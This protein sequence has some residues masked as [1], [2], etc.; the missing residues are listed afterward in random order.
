MKKV[1]L[2]FGLI[3]LAVMLFSQEEL[4]LEI[5]ISGNQN[6]DK[7]LILSLLPFEVGDELN[8][9][10]ISKT[11]KNL[12]QLGVFDDVKFFAEPLPQGI[13]INIEVLEYPIINSIEFSGNKKIKDHTFEDDL[14]M[15]EGNYWSPFLKAETTRAISEKYKE[16]GYHM[17]E[18]EFI[19]NSISGNKIDLTV[20]ITENS[21][22]VIKKINIHGNKKVP[23]KDIL[24][25]IKT[26]KKSLFRS[27]KFEQEKFIED[28]DRI[29]TYYNKNGFIDANII[30]WG[31]KVVDGNFIIDIYVFEGNVYHF[32]K[33]FV[34]GNKRFTEDI[35]KSQFKFNKNEI[36]D[37]EK[38]NEQLGKVSSMY[39]EEG[40]IYANFEHELLKT[41]D[42]IDIELNISENNRAQVRKIHIAGNR[43]T[44]EKIIRRQLVISPG[45]YFQQSKLMKSQQNI[46]NLGF[47]E[48]DIY[49]DNPKIINDDGDI[50]LTINV[51]DKVSGTA[52]GGV[53][54]NSQE[55]LVGQLS[56]SHNNLLGNAWK[57][58]F[59]WEF[60][61]QTQNFTLSFTNPYFRD[62]NT[63]IGTDIYHTNR[64]WDI[65]EVFTNGASIR[66]GRP[67]PFL[68]YSRLVLGYSLYSKKYSILNGE[69]E[70][71]SE[72]LIEL[73][74][75][76]WQNNS[77]MSLT[78]S[79]DSRD[80]VFFPTSGSNFTL[81]SEVAGGYL[82]GDFNYYKQIA[83]V[84]WFN[85]ILWKL[86]LRTKWRFGYV[87]GYDN[88]SA[89]PDERFYLGGTGPDGIRGYADR[90]VGPSEGA[91]REIL[92]STELGVPIGSDQFVGI[93]FFDNGD[94][95]HHFEDFNFW[96]MK[97]GAGLGIRVRSPFGLIGFDYAHNFE[98]RS[99]EPHFQFGTTF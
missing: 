25:K 95:Y 65:Y 71:A 45:N 34:K 28:L 62:T 70:Q 73:D 76:G 57:G 52:N 4:I 87:N 81:Y 1:L 50:D 27:G 12:Y 15:K 74:E 13:A 21:K 97:K 20:K 16:K 51:N 9:E 98:N 18:T 89:P 17:A 58:S 79:R 48:P 33:I 59:K 83:E 2:S 46:Y 72:T 68:N 90:S 40:Y 55:G 49:V 64:E 60:G 63:L 75:E 69:E 91:L 61:G 94:G 19:T 31:K 88:K 77:S 86:V 66:L 56:V 38:F 67:I 3:M 93:I 26:K 39:Y 43:K 78:I 30:N 47:F 10:Y 8:Y 36:F 7:E 54:L 41:G 44:K 80:N 5:N 14:E 32:G 85:R 22:V 96:E 82:Q 23:S 6:I 11:I 29:I 84:S 35:I 53:A 99:W 24:K 37:L 92:F 42:K